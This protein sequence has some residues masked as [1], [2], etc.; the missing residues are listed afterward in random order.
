M[1]A[2]A[3]LPWVLGILILILWQQ[4]PYGWLLLLLMS[5][6]VGAALMR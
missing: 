1:M 2:R 3:A 6:V 5:A 4:Q